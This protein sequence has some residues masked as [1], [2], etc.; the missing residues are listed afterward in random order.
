MSRGMS[1]PSVFEKVIYSS[2]MILHTPI[3]T[4]AE[5]NSDDTVLEPVLHMSDVLTDAY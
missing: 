1:N 5:I 2:S 3:L 4:A